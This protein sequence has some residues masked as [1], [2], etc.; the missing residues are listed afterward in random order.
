MSAEDEIREASRQFYAGLSRMA[1]GESGALV[2]IWS[3]SAA[4]T[5]M[6][7]IGG[8][9]VGWDAVGES[10]DKVAQLASDGKVGLKDQLIQVAGD[11]AYEVGI[12]QGQVKLGGQQVTLEHRVTNIYRREAG[13]WKLVHHHT[14]ISPAMLDVLS[15]LPPP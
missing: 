13:A 12:E 6:H 1:N 9:E 4:V 5:T 3:H 11:V 7:P 15:R 2:D 10:F 14:D 8:R